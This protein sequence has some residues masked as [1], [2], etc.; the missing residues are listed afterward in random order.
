M[1][2]VQPS[3]RDNPVA[4]PEAGTT[5]VAPAPFVITKEHRR[6]AEFADAVRLLVTS[7]IRPDSASNAVK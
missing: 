6:F 1:Q 3:P 7:D 4:S 2:D 5:A